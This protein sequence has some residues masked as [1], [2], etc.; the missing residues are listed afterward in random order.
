MNDIPIIVEFEESEFESCLND[1]EIKLSF[2]VD[3]NS[4]H[5]VHNFNDWNFLSKFKNLKILEAFEI[6]SFYWKYVYIQIWFWDLVLLIKEHF[7]KNQ[8]KSIFKS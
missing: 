2:I 3:Y 7:K 8:N 1:E 4:G 6:S 5:L